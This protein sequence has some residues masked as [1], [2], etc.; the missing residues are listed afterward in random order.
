MYYGGHSDLYSDPHFHS[1]LVG[2]PVIP[3]R[4]IKV[5][6]SATNYD[7]FTLISRIGMTGL[8][9]KLER[10]WWTPVSFRVTAIVHGQEIQITY[11]QYK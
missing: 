5:N 8:P 6:I 2:I 1:N 9:T 10:K 3:V 4:E 7:A 11:P